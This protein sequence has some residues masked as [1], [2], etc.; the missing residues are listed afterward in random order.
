MY[1]IT[2]VYRGLQGLLRVEGLKTSPSI[3]PAWATRKA[4]EDKEKEDAN[5]VFMC[6]V[7]QKKAVALK[8]LKFVGKSTKLQQSQP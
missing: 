4:L 7:P 1:R 6:S 3:T 2:Y 8:Q 5:P